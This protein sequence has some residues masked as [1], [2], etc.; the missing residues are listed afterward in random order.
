V[1]VSLNRSCVCGCVCEGGAGGGRVL[2]FLC[3]VVPASTCE[4]ICGCMCVCVCVNLNRVCVFFPHLLDTL[5]A[6][7]LLTENKSTCIYMHK[8]IYIH[9]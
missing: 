1:G 9:T 8:H 6:V 2:F 5:C 3:F 7:I 4:G